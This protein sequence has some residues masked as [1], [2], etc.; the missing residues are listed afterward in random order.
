MTAF[1]K[2]WGVVKGKKCSYCKTTDEE[3]FS[4]SWDDY[5]MTCARRH[6]DEYGGFD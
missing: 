1:D 3:N 2:A 4:S 6:I 5:C